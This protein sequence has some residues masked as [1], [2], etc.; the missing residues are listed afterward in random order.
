MTLDAYLAADGAKTLTSLSLEMGVSK[1]RLSQLRRSVEWPP[2]LALKVERATIGK[3][4]AAALSR[5]IAE[6]RAEVLGPTAPEQ[7]A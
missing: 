3:L 5:I 7:S 4:D 2:E 6:A 1:G